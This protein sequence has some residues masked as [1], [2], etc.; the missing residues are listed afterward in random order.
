[1]YS[2]GFFNNKSCSTIFPDGFF[3][4]VHPAIIRTTRASPATTVA[5]VGG[6][7]CGVSTSNMGRQVPQAF[8]TRALA[9][10]G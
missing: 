1:M 3:V 4:E 6:N 9:S 2:L 7:V 8:L 5:A 10:I